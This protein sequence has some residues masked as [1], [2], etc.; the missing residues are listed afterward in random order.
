MINDRKIKLN[1]RPAEASPDV[2]DGRQLAKQ[3]NL[4]TKRAIGKLSVKPM[5]AVVVF[6]ND[7]ANLLYARLKAK[8]AKRVGIECRTFKIQQDTTQNELLGLIS[9]LN[10]QPRINGI[11]VQLPLPNGIDEH[12]I[13]GAIDPDKDVDGMTPVN[14]GKLLLGVSRSKYFYPVGCTPLGV[15]VMLDNYFGGNHFDRGYFTGKRALIIGR[16]NIVG[17]PLTAM[18]INHGAEVTILNHYARDRS[19]LRN[20]D[21]IIG[22]TNQAN[23]IKSK[24]VKR[25]H[26]QVMV[27]VGENTDSNGRLAGNFTKPALR[28]SKAYTPVPGGVGPMTIAMLLRQTLECGQQQAKNYD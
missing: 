3:I 28:F 14:A 10:N 15:M 17:K 27:D 2:I 5:L 8:K 6:A 11:I 13:A 9:S 7:Q 25:N 24:F 16:S 22:A 19:D 20:H 21:I 4:K 12:V 23:L 1:H 26:S 18:L